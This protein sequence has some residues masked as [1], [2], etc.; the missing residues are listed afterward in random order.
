MMPKSILYGII[1]IETLALII[2]GGL[3]LSQPTNDRNL[4]EISE[5]V[6]SLSSRAITVYVKTAGTG[7]RTTDIVGKAYVQ[8][9]ATG[10]SEFLFDV[11]AGCFPTW[12]LDPQTGYNLLV[13]DVVDV[14][15]DTLDNLMRQGALR[16]E[17]SIHSELQI[18]KTLGSRSATLMYDNKR[19]RLN[20]QCS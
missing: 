2:L 19:L 11:G 17:F 4:T 9:D 10:R 1:L 16:Y 13:T 6:A 15:N 20:Q 12:M 5:P 7:E 8:D 18:T 3:L 14:D